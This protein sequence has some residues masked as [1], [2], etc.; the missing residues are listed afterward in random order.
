MRIFVLV[1]FALLATSPAPADAQLS[2]QASAQMFAA[3][4]QRIVG[5]EI[6][7]LE[8]RYALRIERGTAHIAAARWARMDRIARISLH[9]PLAYSAS[10]PLGHRGTFRVRVLDEESH[11][12]AFQMISTLPECHGD[13][14]MIRPEETEYPC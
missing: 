14:A 2:P 4:C 10:C 13:H 3:D 7:A 12:L 1:P 9:W 11:E 5:R 8:R 6:P